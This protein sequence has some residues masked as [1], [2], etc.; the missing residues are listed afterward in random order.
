MEASRGL[1]GETLRDGHEA[2][3]LWTF[4][5]AVIPGVAPATTARI[6]SDLRISG[7]DAPTRASTRGAS[8]VNGGL[9]FTTLT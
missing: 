1:M 7:V 8:G 2:R 3:R 9:F 5:G 4:L 6:Q